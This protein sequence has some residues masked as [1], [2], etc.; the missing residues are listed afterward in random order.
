MKLLY[1]LAVSAALISPAF[2]ADKSAPKPTLVEA[3]P[4][5]A[6]NGCYV[7]AAA[8]GLFL[9]EGGNGVSA[10]TLGGEVG[11][12]LHRSR[13]VFGVRA[14]YDFGE[15]D[16]R[17]ATIAG[18]VGLTLNSHALLYGTLN[19][20]MDGRSPK[21]DNA[22]LSAGL[23]LELFAFSNNTTLFV[24]G[25]KAIKGLGDAGDIDDAWTVR[26]GARWR[27]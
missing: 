21:L 12:D 16:T 7:G 17:V 14:G 9:T 5:P 18:R 19:L 11:C 8:G 15:S 20:A 3:E 4:A 22:I 26:A 2:A 10:S 6:F 23:G 25:A 1:A 13:V 27:F 24:E